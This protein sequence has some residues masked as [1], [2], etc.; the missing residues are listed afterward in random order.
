VA[1]NT[2]DGASG[3]FLCFADAFSW[4]LLERGA[5][6]RGLF[7]VGL[8]RICSSLAVGLG[9]G[10]GEGGQVVGFGENSD[11]LGLG[12]RKIAA[13]GDSV[14]YLRMLTER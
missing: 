8:L 9:A 6:E 5:K 7:G 11:R 1:G 14:T 13:G 3:V 2:G 4:Y 12:L 10:Q